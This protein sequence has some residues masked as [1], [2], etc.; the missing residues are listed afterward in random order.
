[1][2][3]TEAESRIHL[4]S[5]VVKNKISAGE[6]VEG[7]FSVVKELMENSLD[8]GARRIEVQVL[9]GGMKRISITDDGEGIHREDISL[10]VTEHAT[11]KISDVHDIEEIASYG[12][13]GEALSSISS[14][15]DMTLLTRR[16]EESEGGRLDVRN[17][18]ARTGSY[19]GPAGTTVIVENLFYNVPARKKFLKSPRTEMKYIRETV[20]KAALANHDVTFRLETDGKESLIF[21]GTSDPDERIRQVYGRDILDNCY[22][23][24][25]SDLKVSLTGYLSRP[26]YLKGTR[27]AQLLFING[28][29]VEY[30]YLG[31]LLTRAYEAVAPRGKHPM[32]VLF[33]EIEPN[34]MDVNIHPAKREV[35]LFDQRYIDSLI[36]SLAS[37]AL[38]RDHA[39]N[40]RFFHEGEVNAPA[41]G[42]TPGVTGSSRA[43]YKERETASRADYHASARPISVKEESTAAASTANTAPLPEETLPGMRTF[44]GFYRNVQTRSE[45]IL[46]IVFDTYI[47]VEREGSLYFIDFHAAHERFIYDGLLARQGEIEKQE[48]LVP[49]II[50]LPPGDYRLLLDYLSVFLE[51]GFD[52]EDFSDNSIT[53][54]T[55]PVHAGRLN[56]KEFIFGFLEELLQEKGTTEIRHIIAASAACHQAKRA[57]DTLSADDMQRIVRGAFSG[58]YELR[59]PHGRPFVHRITRGDL[60]RIFKRS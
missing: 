25:V 1:M 28:R 3:V 58:E 2:T 19:A 29:P 51:T 43:V 21:Q 6:V 18:E 13:R 24:S 7:P 49:E 40:E 30:R 31:F 42:E 22:R 14:I 12:F 52:I 15:S 4:L 33:M 27:A 16:H 9:D 34:L 37:K 8:A 17:G 56:I 60:E 44:E 36:I 55:V 48:L 39:I 35:K 53:V 5:E 47:A 23:E 20:L 32:A 41:A 59:C 57:G 11:S 50:E 10:A 54:R 38:D 45:G 26:H 46:G